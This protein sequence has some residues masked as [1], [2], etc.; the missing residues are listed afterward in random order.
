[1]STAATDAENEYL[2]AVLKEHRL[3]ARA[4]LR[5]LFPSGESRGAY[6]DADTIRYIKSELEAIAE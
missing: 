1:M 4:L 3:S 2:R 5:T 6:I